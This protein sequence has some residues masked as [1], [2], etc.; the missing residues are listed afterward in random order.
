[1]MFGCVKSDG[2]TFHAPKISFYKLEYP[3]IFDFGKAISLE[4]SSTGKQGF[5]HKEQI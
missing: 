4:C 2:V 1:M 5:N 3:E